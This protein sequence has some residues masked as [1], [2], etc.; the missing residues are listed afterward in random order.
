MYFRYQCIHCITKTR[1]IPVFGVF[2]SLYFIDTYSSILVEVFMCF[3]AG[4]R[5]LKHAFLCIA[6]AI[7]APYRSYHI[8][9]KHNPT[10]VRI[11]FVLGQLQRKLD[12]IRIYLCGP[13]SP[14][15]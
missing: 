6:D 2:D 5:T 10:V 12:L 14:S 13:S 15:W 8:S 1:T 3:E 9:K 7:H 4:I 11:Y